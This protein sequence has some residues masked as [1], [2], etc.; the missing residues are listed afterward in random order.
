MSET[1][2]SSAAVSHEAQPRKFDAVA[3]FFHWA[4][5]LAIAVSLV[6]AWYIETL[7]S[8]DQR[9]GLLAIHKSVGITI[10]L[11]AVARL[12]WRTFHPAPQGLP[13]SL[14][15]HI[16]AKATHGLLYVLIVAMPITGYVAEA[17][18]GRATAFFGWFAVP[19]MTPLGRKLSFY[20]EAA[21]SYAQYAL[22][23]LVVLHVGAALYH[24]IILRDGIMS[25][26]WPTRPR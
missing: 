5:V 18:R 15:Q 1:L 23:V 7:D 17:A 19:R 25:R 13:A 9:T 3:M 8:G 26:M 10:F 22:Y 4:V 2:M 11:L 14:W 16:A 24:Q 12:A 20:A 6:L 21:H